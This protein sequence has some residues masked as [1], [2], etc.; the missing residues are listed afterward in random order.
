MQTDAQRTTNA[1][2]HRDLMRA[3]LDDGKKRALRLPNRGSITY[4]ETGAISQEILDSYWQYGFYVFTGVLRADEIEELRAD[5]ERVL[6]GAPSS[7]GDPLD[8]HGQPAVGHQFKR[9][10]FSFSKPLSD[11]LGGTDLNHGRHPVKMAEPIPDEDAP[12]EFIDLLIGNL[13]IMDSC[14]RLYGHP[15]LLTVA[16]AVNGDDFVPFNEV[17]FLKEPGL[18]VS[19]AWHQDGTTHWDSA[20]WNQGKHGF[21]F[22]AQIYGSTPS[23]GVWVVP[24]T[25]KQGKVDIKALVQE[26]GSE[27]ISSAVPMVCDTG[28]V[29]ISN[30][31]LV[32]GSFANTSTERR[33]TLNM[34]FL[35]RK[36]VLNVTNVNFAGREQ[37][38]DEKRVH[39]RSRMIAIGID[40]RQQRFPEEQRYVYQPLVGEE[41]LNRWNE[42][43]RE[44]VV[45]DYNLLDVHL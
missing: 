10:S 41:D 13:Q 18:G 42:E 36:S 4:D 17:T 37:T 40:A 28:D 19:V 8:R 11:P 9:P 15:D 7:R 6:D 27:R 33:V 5:V 16:A 30:R 35:P 12:E 2:E 23:N 29:V 43:T 34:G 38:Y 32:H 31:Q 39:Q 14:L 44:A 3:Y 25:H 24:G 22:M 45:K 21:N 26:S 20:D 1:I